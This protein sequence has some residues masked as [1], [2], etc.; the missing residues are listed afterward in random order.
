MVK[1]KV[2]GKINIATNKMK[3][4]M[5]K[6]INKICNGENNYKNILDCAI[7]FHCFPSMVKK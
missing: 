4:L 6:D 1:K 5:Q 3:M 2:N 7:D